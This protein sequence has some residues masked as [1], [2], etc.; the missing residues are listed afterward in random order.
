LAGLDGIA[1]KPFADPALIPKQVVLFFYHTG[2][3]PAGLRRA[4][5]NGLRL[6][7]GKVCWNRPKTAK[8]IA[9]PIPRSMEVWVPAF[10]RAQTGRSEKTYQRIVEEAGV[11]LGLPGLTPR[12]LRHDYL[13]RVAE[14]TGDIREV[15]RLGGTTMATAIGYINSIE[16]PSDALFREG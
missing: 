1:P 13:T 3:H 7:R 11:A 5:K 8:P 14:T 12:S 6:D 2:I 4:A 16:H 9:V 10:I 15:Q